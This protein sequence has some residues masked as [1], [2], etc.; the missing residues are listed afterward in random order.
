M[1]PS[2]NQT[3]KTTNKNETTTP[4]D[5]TTNQTTDQQADA[6]QNQEQTPTPKASDKQAPK[7]AKQ[8]D[9]YLHFKNGNNETLSF[10]WPDGR[11]CSFTIG[12]F[13]TNDPEVIKRMEQTQ[14]F[15]SGFIK[16]YIP[17]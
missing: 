8:S 15:K 10:V 2:K 11:L 7:K 14:D 12:I 6:L 17:E 16:E 4:A 5:Q 1:A 13:S 3:S 9:D